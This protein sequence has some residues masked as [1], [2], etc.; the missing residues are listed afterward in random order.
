MSTK[1]EYSGF[2]VTV[3]DGGEGVQPWGGHRC[4]LSTVTVEGQGHKLTGTY[5]G[6]QNDFGDGTPNDPA[7]AARMI[8]DDYASYYN[9][10]EEFLAMLVEGIKTGNDLARYA[11]LIAGMDEAVTLLQTIAETPAAWM[12]E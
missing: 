8:C 2:T 4:Y 11:R 7:D 3:E 1:I 5:H 10:P 9:D 6:S 12:D